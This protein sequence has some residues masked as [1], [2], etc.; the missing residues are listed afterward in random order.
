MFQLFYFSG[1]TKTVFFVIFTLPLHFSYN[2]VFLTPGHCISS[3]L[4]SFS[5]KN[6]HSCID[7]SL[8]F[9]L[10]PI[11]AIHL[12]QSGDRN[13]SL[14]ERMARSQPGLRAGNSFIAY[15]RG[16]LPGNM[17]MSTWF[18]FRRSGMESNESK[19]FSP[20]APGTIFLMYC[21]FGDKC[22]ILAFL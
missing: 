7:S 21:H 10:F 16:P 20:T 15:W 22:N 9:A 4:H 8:S 19:L 3:Y 12:A 6:T 1:E 18:Y 14:A 2:V 5:R 13:R 11:P 17:G